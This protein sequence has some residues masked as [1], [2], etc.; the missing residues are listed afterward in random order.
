[1]EAWRR[2]QRHGAG[3]QAMC[4]LSAQDWA[5][6]LAGHAEGSNCSELRPYRK[7]Q[8]VPES[9]VWG[10]VWFPRSLDVDALYKFQSTTCV[11]RQQA[12]DST[13]EEITLGAEA[14]PHVH[15]VLRNR[16]TRRQAVV[17]LMWR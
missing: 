3:S 8:N 7:E 16:R 12:S 11:L 10:M 2:R 5:W 14:A 6:F 15:A 9:V 13:D 4:S 17:M 1:M